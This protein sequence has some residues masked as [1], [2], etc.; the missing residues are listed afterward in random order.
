MRRRGPARPRARAVPGPLLRLGHRGI[1]VGALVAQGRQ[2]GLDLGAA[3]GEALD[4][5]ALQRQALL[6]GVG[7]V[8]EGALAL[9]ADGQFLLAFLQR[10]AD[11]GEPFLAGLHGIAR[12]FVLRLPLAAGGAGGGG[13]AP[14]ARPRRVPGGGALPSGRRWARS[15]FALAAARRSR[16]SA[17]RARGRRTSAASS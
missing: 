1:E 3:A 12:R 11:G 16:A 14:A 15:S 7:L 17:R 5:L 2:L 9:A 10:G 6:E 4:A 13:G 8:G